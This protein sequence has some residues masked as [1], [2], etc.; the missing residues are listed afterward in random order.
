M[1]SL[2]RPDV[3]GMIA[4]A[5]ILAV[6]QQQALAPGIE[7]LVERIE[8]RYDDAAITA[9]FVQNRLT[10]LGSV[11]TSA[12]G[13]LYIATPGR[14]RWEYA[15][16]DRL[17]VAG[18]VGR[19]TYFYLP[20]DNQVSVIQTDTANPSQYPILYLSGRGNLRRDFD[21]QVVEW[22]TPLARGNVQ[23][24]LRPRRSG[25]S[26]QR[27]VIEVDPVRA[28]ISRPNCLRNSTARSISSTT[29]NTTSASTTGSSSSRF[30]RARTWCS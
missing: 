18:G 21:V 17:L 24:E 26:F 9:H 22:G 5:G 19:E 30:P 27:L 16:T 13:E 10:R 4:A 3:V 2:P 29:C 7:S 14:M 11:M 1:R 15:T 12:E 6:S 8:E 23:L 28:T 20:E 25:A